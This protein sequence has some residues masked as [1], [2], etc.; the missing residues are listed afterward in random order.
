MHDHISKVHHQ[1]AF[2][3]LTFDAASFLVIFFCGFEHALGQ[4]VQHTVAGAIAQDEIISKGC[5][6]LDVKQQN[7][8]ALF[9]LQG[10]DDFMCKVECVQVSPQNLSL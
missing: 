3:R 8:F 4:R 6:I 7:V 10:V 5:D 2:A 9:I 1:P